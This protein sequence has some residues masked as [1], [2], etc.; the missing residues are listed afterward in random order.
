[1]TDADFGTFDPVCALHP[2]S[3]EQVWR[4]FLDKVEDWTSGGSFVVCIYSPIE[5]RFVK[6]LKRAYGGCDALERFEAQIVDLCQAVKSSVVLPT[7]GDG[8]KTVA[9]HIGFHW[10]DATSGGAQSMTWWG[11]YWSDP[12]THAAQRDRVHA[13]N[14]DDVRATFAIRDWLEALR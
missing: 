6:Q 9:S 14:E 8:L 10:R 1:L 4:A 5:R 13:Y 3:E 12:I 11:E 2:Q 7:Y